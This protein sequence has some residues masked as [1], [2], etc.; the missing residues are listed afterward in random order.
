MAYLVFV[1]GSFLANRLGCFLIL[2]DRLAR[3]SLTRFEKM[4]RLAVGGLLGGE[5]LFTEKGSHLLHG[6]RCGGGK[7][8]AQH[9]S[10]VA[11][12]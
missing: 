12:A 5:S 11:E 10:R 6:A 1:S 9:G 4:E 3:L 7:H 8:V 2:K